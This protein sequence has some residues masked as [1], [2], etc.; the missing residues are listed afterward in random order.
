MKSFQNTLGKTGTP[1]TTLKKELEFTGIGLHTGLKTTVELRPAKAGTG[2]L[3]LTEKGPVRATYKNAVD[4]TYALTLADRGAKV[5]TC[6]HLLAALYGAGVNNAVCELFGSSEIPLLDGS[7]LLFSRA[8]AKAGV[9]EYKEKRRQLIFNE[10]FLVTELVSG[11]TRFLKAEPADTLKIKY[12]VSYDHPAIG[13]LYREYT[14]KPGA[15]IKEISAAR[16]FG[17]AEQIKAQ[18]KLGLIKGGSLKNALLFGKKGV[19]NKGGLRFKD[20]VVRHKIL[21]LIAAVALLPFE[22]KG[23]FTAFKSGHNIDIKMIKKIGG[24][25]E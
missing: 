7:S 23:C 22:V 6:E 20:E 21:D 19:E 11:T 8:L 4:G 17:W 25:Y 5:Q 1:Q 14:Q 18:K 24:Y 16:T 9:T 12:Y 3:F 10:D 13:A 2:I 15:F